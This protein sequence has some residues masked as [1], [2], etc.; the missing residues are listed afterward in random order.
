MN[1]NFLLLFTLDMLFL[2]NDNFLCQKEK[3]SLIICEIV[4]TL[5][6]QNI[7]RRFCN[8]I[9]SLKQNAAQIF[10]EE[11][12]SV[13]LLKITFLRCFSHLHKEI[14]LHLSELVA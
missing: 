12:K 11:R 14:H 5:S 3:V 8:C 1:P 6:L 7:R 2:H 4:K 13:R 9:P 10:G